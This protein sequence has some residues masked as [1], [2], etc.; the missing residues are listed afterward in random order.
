M[1]KHM[2]LKE[3]DPTPS[4]TAESLE[5]G[6]VDPKPEIEGVMM[7]DG[8]ESGAGGATDVESEEGWTAEGGRADNSAIEAD[9]H[10][11]DTDT[12]DTHR[13]P[14]KRRIEYDNSDR[15]HINL[16]QVS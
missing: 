15:P 10:D 14:A 6:K 5:D 4:R 8:A 7:S 2:E 11:H 3:L 1:A 16:C 9:D 12:P 13:S